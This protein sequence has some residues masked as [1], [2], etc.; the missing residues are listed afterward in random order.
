MRLAR[1]SFALLTLVALA[2]LAGCGSQ[3][4]P[5]PPSLE[6]PRP[7]N[8]LKAARKG[9]KVLLNW[10]APRETTDKLRIKEAGK[11]LVC[12]ATAAPA[13]M[14][15]SE[16]APAPASGAA[17][18][19]DT[20]PR[21]LQ[22]QSLAGFAV[23]TV[24]VTNARGRS[25]GPSNPVRVPLAPTL[26]PPADLKA[27][28]APGG[29]FLTW[30]GRAPARR[31]S[32][33]HESSYRIYRQV[34]VQ[35]KPAGKVAV[36]LGE[37]GGIGIVGLSTASYSFL[38]KAAE[39]EQTYSYWV[40]SVTRLTA[41]GQSVEVEGEDAPMVEVFVHD[42][43]PPAA[44]TAVEAVASSGGGQSFID[45][46]W[47]LNSE[48]DLAGYDVYRREAGGQPQKINAELVKTPAF[49]DPNVTAGHTYL[50]SVSAVDLR[51]NESG[52]SEETSETVPQP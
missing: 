41:E 40:T 45:L 42:A 32:A 16:A 23:Y 9:D 10:T 25:A 15:C 20:L 50:Y 26:P 47:S 6:L 2:L 49:R 27:E 48:A 11:T 13:S 37:M 24:E 36:G 29:V 17:S 8:D 28:V 35:G 22:E 21:E 52:R 4:N 38:D 51:A 46:T 30:Q 7:V 34:L 33:A 43:F 31:G 39:W 12:R 3:G 1:P 14:D 5:L 44:P 19:T 18:F